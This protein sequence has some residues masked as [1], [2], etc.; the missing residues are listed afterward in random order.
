MFTA[1]VADRKRGWGKSCSKSCAAIKGNR[2]TGKFQKF[3]G[4]CDSYKVHHTIPAH[5]GADLLV[6]LE[7]IDQRSHITM[8]HE[9]DDED[10]DY[11]DPSWDA[12]KD[13]F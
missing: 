4:R 9:S 6:N 5:R 2:E 3:L 13:Q 1:R 7:R 12:H 8:V 11:F 10:D